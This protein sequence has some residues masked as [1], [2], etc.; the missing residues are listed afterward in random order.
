MLYLLCNSC[1]PVFT[2]LA[3]R[4]LAESK[5]K[6]S[7]NGEQLQLQIFLEPDSDLAAEP[8]RISRLMQKLQTLDSDPLL[9]GGVC[10]MGFRTNKTWEAYDFR[11][12]YRHASVYVGA[13]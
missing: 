7:R 5:R 4:L 1:N 10:A 2:Q 3:L 8:D 9:F 11:S 12:R 6:T 13:K